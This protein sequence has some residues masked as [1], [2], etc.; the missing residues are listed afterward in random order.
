M[1]QTKRVRV[2]FAV[3]LPLS[4]L[5]F[6]NSC[7][8]QRSVPDDRTVW[9]VHATD[10]HLYLYAAEDATDAVKKST[11]FE[12]SHDRDVLS[13]FFQHIRTLPQISGPPAFILITG[14]F[15]V[16]PCLIPNAD[17]LKKPEKTRTLDDCVTK[18]D[19]KKRDDE[20]EALSAL[21]AASP[22]RNICTFDFV[23]GNND[24][25]FETRPDD[26]WHRILQSVLPGCSKQD[27]D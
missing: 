26:S 27:L 15:G 4:V 6:A 25:P 12:E 21:F 20:V 22:V 13:Q 18:F 9:F 23:A 11:A 3:T 8:S 10:P 17:T 16:D 7:T 2:I 19:A 24:L 14:D 1:T 5:L